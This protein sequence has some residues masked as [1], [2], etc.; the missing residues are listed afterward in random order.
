MFEL[1]KLNRD[2]AV[3][4]LKRQRMYFG[5][6]FNKQWAEITQNGQ[7]LEPLIEAMQEVFEGLDEVEISRGLNTMRTKTFVP[8][9]PEFRSWCRPGNDDEWLSPDQAWAISIESLD[10]SKT[11]VWSDEMAQAFS[12]VKALLD[13]GDKFSAARAFKDR[14]A[15]LVAQAKAKGE[16]PK[17]Y[18]SLGHDPEHRVIAVKA[19][20]EMGMLKISHDQSQNMIG[21]L[22]DSKQ[23]IASKVNDHIAKMREVLGVTEQSIAEKETKRLAEIEASKNAQM[24]ALEERQAQRHIDP[25]DD[26]ELY[27]AQIANDPMMSQNKERAHV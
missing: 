7:D 15:S 25:F 23:P 6:K 4:I 27:L 16:K 1:N 2:W 24:Q 8:S 20:Q 12:F 19:V 10:E 21:Y 14:Y 9:L 13:M 11:I 17:M 3:G 22:E 5:E 18:A 26:N